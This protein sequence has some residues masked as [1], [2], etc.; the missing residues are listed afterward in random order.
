MSKFVYD[1]SDEL[2]FISLCFS[3]RHKFLDG[4]GCTAF[5]SGIPN[6]ILTG[7]FIHRKRHREQKNNIV[8]GEKNE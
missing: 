7:K 5:P 3:C 2:E 8:Y 1:N 6:D 4:V